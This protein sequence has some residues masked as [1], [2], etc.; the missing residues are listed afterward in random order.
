MPYRDTQ[1]A[2]HQLENETFANQ[3]PHANAPETTCHPET[4]NQ[5]Y[6]SLKTT[7][8]QVICLAPC[9]RTQNHRPSRDTQTATHQPQ[10][11]FFATHLPNANAPKTTCHPK[12][13]KQQHVSHKATLLQPTSKQDC[14]R[15]DSIVLL[16]GLL[17]VHIS[18][19]L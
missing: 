12:T 13:P 6:I 9:T 14:K 10:N 15:G 3:F 8:L 5:R 2:T 4:P 17:A 18:M 19:V 7:L 1:K 11:N 16:L